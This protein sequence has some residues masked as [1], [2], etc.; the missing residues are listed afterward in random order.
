MTAGLNEKSES[1]GREFDKAIA[2]NVKNFGHGIIHVLRVVDSVHFNRSGFE[3]IQTMSRFE[4]MMFGIFEK[5]TLDPFVIAWKNSPAII[6]DLG[7]IYAEKLGRR[8]Y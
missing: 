1:I 2:D 4:R 8:A 5:S 6:R 3:A 7:Y